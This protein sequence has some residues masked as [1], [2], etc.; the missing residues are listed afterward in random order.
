MAATHRSISRSSAQPA[1]LNP[2][3]RGIA[4]GGSSFMPRKAVQADFGAIRDLI[5]AEA[6]LS[7]KVID[8]D[9]ER[10]K[11]WISNGM[12][13][14]AVD[15][16]GSIVS[17]VALDRW[18]GCVEL[19]SAVTV[20]GHRG[21]GIYESM[22]AAILEAHFAEPGAVPVVS[23][24]NDASNG[25]RLKQAAGFKEVGLAEAEATGLRLLKP[26]AGP[27]TVYLLTQEAYLLAKGLRRDGAGPNAAQYA[28]LA[29]DVAM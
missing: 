2:D 26:E 14:V 15:E 18:P 20:P 4:A 22:H 7:G 24:K 9:D 19:V 3:F 28:G 25:R 12:S 27:W 16:N 1:G 21:K 13:F 8:R 29:R 6:K 5:A 11:E 17:H 23:V 10:I